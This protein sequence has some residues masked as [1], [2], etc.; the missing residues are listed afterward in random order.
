MLLKK[1]KETAKANEEKTKQQMYLV[2][3]G[4]QQNS[5]G[6]GITSSCYFYLVFELY[7]TQSLLLEVDAFLK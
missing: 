6:R 4:E 7:H 2:R 5:K 1:T 3:E